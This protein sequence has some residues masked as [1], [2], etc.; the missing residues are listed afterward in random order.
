MLYFEYFSSAKHCHFIACNCNSSCAKA[1]FQQSGVNLWALLKITFFF[2]IHKN[3]Q[4]HKE[5]QLYSIL[6]IKI[7][8]FFFKV[9][10]PMVRTHFYSYEEQ[11]VTISTL[12][13][14]PNLHN[15]LL[16]IQKYIVEELGIQGLNSGIKPNSKCITM[17]FYSIF[18]WLRHHSIAEPAMDLE[19]DYVGFKFLLSYFLSL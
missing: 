5:N 4:N 9:T 18:K 10:D 7:F 2:S 3:T 16:E 15:T 13:F 1:L 6:V 12:S 11:L 8:F 14:L 19:T 17:I